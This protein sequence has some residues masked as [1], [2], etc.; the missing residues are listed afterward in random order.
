MSAA[1][2]RLASPARSAVVSPRQSPASSPASLAS[3]PPP[4]PLPT[5]SG[6][7]TAHRAT[8]PAACGRQHATWLQ[9][10]ASHTVTRPLASP[11]ASH[12]PATSPGAGTYASAVTSAGG[13]ADAAA[14]AAVAGVVDATAVVDGGSAVGGS[15]GGTVVGGTAVGGDAVGGTVGDGTATGRGTGGAAIGAA[16][17]AGIGSSGTRAMGVIIILCV[18][19]GIRHKHTTPRRRQSTQSSHCHQLHGL[20]CYFMRVLLISVSLCQ[21]RGV[22]TVTVSDDHHDRV[23]SRRSHAATT[24]LN[25]QPTPPL[26]RHILL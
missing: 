16:V 13:A 25:H 9:P 22:S 1:R 4:P 7:A 26:Q 19:C 2:E 8:M 24:P 6:A 21:R 14:A 17:G 18:V 3:P 12:A 10:P 20:L 5:S 15:V 11:A 23:P